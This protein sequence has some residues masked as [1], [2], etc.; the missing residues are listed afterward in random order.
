MIDLKVLTDDQIRRLSR[1]IELEFIDNMRVKDAIYNA[2]K[3][4]LPATMYN[5]ETLTID[6]PLTI[7]GFALKAMV[8]L[9]SDHSMSEMKT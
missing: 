3:S 1:A 9:V 2:L 4:G 7:T 5:D 6:C 8:R